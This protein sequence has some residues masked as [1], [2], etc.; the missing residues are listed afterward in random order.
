MATK[1]SAGEIGALNRVSTSNAL[2][3]SREW[4]S[5]R[6]F[7]LSL[8]LVSA[9][10]VFG[11][12]D[13]A[14][15]SIGEGN[16]AQLGKNVLE[17]GFPKAWNGNYLVVPF[18]DSTINSQLTWVAQPWLQY[19][20]AGAGIAVFG[21]T[22]LGAR[23]FFALCSVFSVVAIYYFALR[24]SGSILLA[25]LSGLLFALHPVVWLYSRQSRYY[26]PTMLLMILT[27]LT[28]LRWRDHSTKRKLALFIIASVFL[29]H[30]LYTIWAFL[31]LGIGIYYLVFDV[32]RENIKAF[33]IATLCIAGLTLPWFLYAPPHFYFDLPPTLAG[34]GNRLIVHLWKIQVL[35]YPLVTVLLIYGV[36]LLLRRGIGRRRPDSSL[37]LRKEFWLLS[38]VVAY[39]LL[40]LVYPFYTTHYM[41]PV[42]P[43]GAIIAAYLLLKIRAQNRW[44]SA[45]VLA[46]MLTTN[47]LGILPYIA[48]E[49]IGVKPET[50][51]AALP[52]PTATMTVGT[53]L[54]HYLTEQLAVRFYAFDFFNFIT[55]ENHHQLK[56]V[57][58]YLK[59]NV[60]PGQTVYT[61]WN[62]A[63]AIAFYTSQ[64]I[65]YHGDSIFLHNQQVKGLLTVP[66]KPDWIIPLA[67]DEPGTKYISEDFL[68]DYERIRL[69]VPKEYFETYPNIEFFNFRTNERAPAWFYILKLKRK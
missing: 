51:E 58:N 68:R 37:R 4:I 50:V 34:Y 65:V 7:I 42:L 66:E 59:E 39:V 24:V 38:S 45:A 29:F 17:F 18:Y 61:P 55:H 30:S 32:S 63:N 12:I 40:I 8:V 9:F 44:L 56:G 22:S 47:C 3:K 20:L 36:V 52:N 53:P 25:R 27:V 11:N 5:R 13:N 10:F 19:Y 69:A 57:V 67:I 49:K 21:P 26:A 46:L 33:T 54:S 35:Y 31:L 16:T 64:K 41:L 48:V 2:E 23:F 15:L 1:I 6:V 60:Q 28:Y 43:F 14:Y 62:D